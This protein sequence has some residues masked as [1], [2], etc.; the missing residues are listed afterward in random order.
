MSDRPK[1]RKYDEQEVANVEHDDTLGVKKVMPYGWDGSN[2]VAIKVDSS[3]KLV[4]S[5]GDLGKEIR[6]SGNYIYIGAS[7]VTDTSQALWK[8]KRLDTTNTLSTK[9]ADGDENYDNV[10]DNYLTL[11]YS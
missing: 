3:G 5:G 11:D 4:I 10:F 7:S 6:V 1:Y 8:I 9:W 2:A